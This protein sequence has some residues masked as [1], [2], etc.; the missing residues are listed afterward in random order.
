MK[1]AIA[2]ILALVLVTAIA[3]TS[4]ADLQYCIENGH[5]WGT[6]EYHILDT[7]IQR[8]IGVK[9]CK[10]CKQPHRHLQICSLISYIDEC[11]SCHSHRP[12]TELSV[13]RT[14]CLHK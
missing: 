7:N 2:F 1:R 9:G 5:V 14:I 6:L 3:I 8:T 13:N 10:E 11:W 12:R 4:F